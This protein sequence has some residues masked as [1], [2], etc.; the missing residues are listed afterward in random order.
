MTHCVF[1]GMEKE[2]TSFNDWVKPTFT[3]HDKLQ[4]GSIVCD[5]CLFWFDERSEKLARIIGK[6]KPQRMRN[7]SHFVVG[8][9]WTPLSK[10]DK[11][12]MQA[13]LLDDSFPELAVIAESGQK[14]IVFR[15]R[16]N[17]PGG[18]SGW[19]QF[20]EQ[21]LFVVPGE[22]KQLLDIIEQLYVGFSKTEI[23]TGNYKGY[24]VVKFGLKCWQA[25][26]ADLRDKRGSL[27]FRL[28]IFLAQKG[29]LDGQRKNAAASCQ[30]VDGDLARRTERVQEPVSPHDLAAVRGQCEGGGIHEQS[31]KIRQLTLFENVC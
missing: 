2:G 7:Y 30:S 25:L 4:D 8:G 1:C 23:E 9:E 26:E 15:A 24:R 16:R 17:L 31:G 18:T 29:E 27:L 14:H 12:K 11:V 20:E 6:D 21:S 13:L 28:T 10:G 5:D 22:L 3:D 19:I